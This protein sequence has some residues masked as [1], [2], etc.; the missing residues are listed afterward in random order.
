MLDMV[1]D[2]LDIEKIQTGRLILETQSVDV[3]QLLENARITVKSKL[4]EHN[5]SL[6]MK[7]KEG[8]PRFIITDE[9]RLRQ[10]V[11]SFLNQ[12]I[13]LNKNRAIFLALKTKKTF[14]FGISRMK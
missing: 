8:T 4:E 9:K 14:L 2:V 5:A 1:N 10:I 6:H 7:V 12:A 3:A 11:L 13:E